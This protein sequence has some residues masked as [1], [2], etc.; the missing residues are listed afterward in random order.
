MKSIYLLGTVIVVHLII[1]SDDWVQCVVIDTAVVGALA[2]PVAIG[3]GGYSTYGFHKLLSY[4]EHKP[5]NSKVVHLQPLQDERGRLTVTK[6]AEYSRPFHYDYIN[7][8]LP[9]KPLLPKRLKNP[10]DAGK[11]YRKYPSAKLHYQL[12]HSDLK[13]YSKLPPVVSPPYLP[14]PL[15]YSTSHQF[16]SR[17]W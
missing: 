2:G 15:V 6:I 8:P 17:Y 5:R 14:L 7:A 1:Y 3:L 10:L 9:S 13:F 16:T 4:L 12:N 11:K